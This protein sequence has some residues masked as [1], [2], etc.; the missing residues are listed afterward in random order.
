MD[1]NMME[2]LQRMGGMGG[3][4]MPNVGGLAEDDDS[5]DE[6]QNSDEKANLDDL[7]G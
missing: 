4:Q 3:E 6:E 5:D 2:Q 7:E 1:M